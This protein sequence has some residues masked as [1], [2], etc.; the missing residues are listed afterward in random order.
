MQRATGDLMHAYLAAY[1]AL[2]F[3][4]RFCLAAFLAAPAWAAPL[5][6]AETQR[7]AVERSTQVV[8][9]QASVTSAREMAIASAQLPDPVLK[10]RSTTC[11]STARTR[12]A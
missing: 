12:S 5:T 8:A 6:L 2:R 9:R 11:R 7:I 10:L 3:A 1:A 4:V